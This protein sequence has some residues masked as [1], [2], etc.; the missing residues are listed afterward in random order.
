MLFFLLSYDGVLLASAALSMA[1]D[2]RLAKMEMF[3]LSVRNAS[4][5]EQIGLLQPSSFHAV[6]APVFVGKYWRSLLTSCFTG[7]VSVNLF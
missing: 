1:C 7:W 4:H 5:A 3:I 6:L 2:V